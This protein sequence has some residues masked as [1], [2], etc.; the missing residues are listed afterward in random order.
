MHLLADKLLARGHLISPIWLSPTHHLSNSSGS[1]D[2]CSFWLFTDHMKVTV[3]TAALT[4]TLELPTFSFFLFLSLSL[5]RPLCRLATTV[6]GAAS[7]PVP[8]L[9]CLRFACR[10]IGA[11][12]GSCLLLAIL[13]MTG[14]ML[15][16]QTHK[17][18]LLHWPPQPLG[19]HHS[20]L[21]REMVDGRYYSKLSSSLY[22][23]SSVVK[24]LITGKKVLTI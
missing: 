8:L 7:S 24:V 21:K 3:F 23:C 17:C 9:F 10:R 18:T 22:S 16:K 5:F 12:F 13:L 11:F 20:Q 2:I 15:H 4:L 19:Y 1:N 6:T 14:R